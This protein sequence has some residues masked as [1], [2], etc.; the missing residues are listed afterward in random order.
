MSDR[1]KHG[2]HVGG[3][4][5]DWMCGA[6]EMGDPDPTVNE[7]YDHLL[8]LMNQR[9]ERYGMLLEYIPVDALPDRSWVPSILADNSRAIAGTLAEIAEARAWS[10]HDDDN[11]WLDRRHDHYED[12]DRQFDEAMQHHYTEIDEIHE[13]GYVPG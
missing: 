6:C 11:R 9:A 13:Y 5:I 7:L 12:L 8:R 2:V 1:C 3:S 10:E 4:G